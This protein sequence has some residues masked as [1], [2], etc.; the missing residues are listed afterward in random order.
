LIDVDDRHRRDAPRRSRLAGDH[1]TALVEF[2]L[3]SPLFF[4][5]V[6]GILEFGSAYAQQ[7]DTSHGARELSR[8]VAVNY[9]W[10]SVPPT[11]MT[12]TQQSDAI[13]AQFCPR[14][15]FGQGA[16]VTMSFTGGARGDTATATVSKPIK[17]ITGF[18][19]FI[20][21]NM[22]SSSTVQVRLEQPATWQSGYSGTCP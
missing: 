6:F 19:G 21:N 18:F 10:G 7:L 11:G 4:L 20:L 14:M 3:I 13:T 22:S 5:L 8:L 15:S 1:G 17:Q 12:A 2:A 16:K 9:P